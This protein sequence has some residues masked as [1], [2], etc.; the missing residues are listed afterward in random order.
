MLACQVCS[1][2]E[3]NSRYCVL[4]VSAPGGFIVDDTDQSKPSRTDVCVFKCEGTPEK[5]RGFY[6]VGGCVLDR[7]VEVCAHT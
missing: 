6:E 7:H 2:T 3:M 4:C 5:I 1:Y